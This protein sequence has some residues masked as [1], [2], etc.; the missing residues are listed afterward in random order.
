[1]SKDNDKLF[2]NRIAVLSTMHGKEQVIAPILQQELGIQVTVPTAF[3]T[4]Y[5]GTFTGE[6]ERAGTQ[7]EAARFKAQRGLERMNESL[8]LAS[9]GSFGPHPSSGFIASN[10][11]I[12]LLLDTRHDLEVF[13]M[14]LST[15]TNHS[16][17]VVRNLK[18]AKDFA[19]QV[20]F[21]QHGL[22]V[23]ADPKSSNQGLLFKGIVSEVALNEAI[24]TVLAQSSTAFL[25]T[26]MR[27][28]YNPT[29][30]KVIAE[31]TQNLAAKL[32][33]Y[34]PNCGWPGFEIAKRKIGLPCEW[35]MSPTELVLAEV[36]ECKK[37]K[38]QIEKKHPDGKEFADPGRCMYC[39]P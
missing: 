36:Y 37:C 9:E 28:M 26:D 12:V 18:E 23:S 30:M 14:A 35:C 21:P 3:D 19:V 22:I 11:E 39:N 24:Q 34:C 4:D 6:I 2:A 38:H 20:G 13:G 33:S 8:G 32:R 16:H 31:A 7:I 10:L 15:N 29:R 25:Q 5:F 17:R 27:A 1:M